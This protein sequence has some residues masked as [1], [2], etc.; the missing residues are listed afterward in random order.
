MS[1]NP[2]LEKNLNFLR[3]HH[4][5]LAEQI[6]STPDIPAIS[7]SRI[8]KEN[9]SPE[10]EIF[11]NFSDGS[12]KP[13]HAGASPIQFSNQLISQLRLKNPGVLVFCGLG[14]AHHLLAYARNPH[15][16]NQKIL[17]IEVFPQ[18]F[19]K[20]LETTDLSPLL[21][22]PAVHWFV[23]ND[24]QDLARFFAEF[25]SHTPH[26]SFA[27]AIEFVPLPFAIEMSP[28]FYEQLKSLLPQ[29]IAHQFNRIYSDPYDAYQGAQNILN[30]FDRLASMPSLD[31]AEGLFQ[32]EPGILIASGPSLKEMIPVLKRMKERAVMIACPSALPELLRNGISPDLW[33]NIERPSEQG[34]FFKD[35]HPKPPHVFIAPPHVHPDCFDYNGGLNTYVLSASLQTRWLP[36]EGVVS[37]LGHSS[38]HAAFQVLTRLGCDSIFLVGQDL[39]YQGD[40]SHA[41][42]VWEESARAMSQLKDSSSKIFKLEGNNGK[43][44]ETNLF[45]FTYLKTFT[46]QLFPR[47]KGQIYNVI[48]ESMGVRIDRTIRID[49]EEMDQKLKNQNRNVLDRL[50]QKLTPPSL[51][52][53]ESQRKKLEDKIVC[54]KRVLKR[55]Q[56]DA[57]HFSLRCKSVRFDVDL[58]S[59]RWECFEKKYKAFLKETADYATR[60]SQ[61]P[62]YAEDRE[63]YQHFFHPIVQGFLLLNQI[64]FFS[65]GA[66]LSGDFKEIV[67]KLELLFHAAKDEAFWAGVCLELLG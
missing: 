12:S 30:N 7:I 33:I 58:A 14:L 51:S 60:F 13:Y 24:P 65:S 9:L 40:E 55:L 18:V 42:G 63:T 1:S 62:A 66:D 39:S 8:Q 21:Q 48:P 46:E 29:A 44:V 4:P 6:L 53:Q 67:R 45:W 15:S 61:N 25:F 23:G 35:L 50:K 26:L 27:N 49:S 31:Q 52:I 32:N 37:D 41:P 43:L 22:S 47:F 57:I 3:L 5:A 38:A 59:Q 36:L 54:A 16:L 17:V 64:D 20:A 56:K 19:K 2:T 10:C 28:Q 34:K 11:C